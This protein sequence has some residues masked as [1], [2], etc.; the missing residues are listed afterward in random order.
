ML[1]IYS[2]H[3]GSSSEDC[4]SRGIEGSGSL[5][6]R[7]IISACEW[8]DLTKGVGDESTFSNAILACGDLNSGGI[9]IGGTEGS[10]VLAD[11]WFHGAVFTSDGG[12]LGGNSGNEKCEFH[13][14]V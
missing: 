6:L 7:C 8:D 10:S 5:F 1:I 9:G 11:E 12:F 2:S 4:G 13:F 3:E 14:L